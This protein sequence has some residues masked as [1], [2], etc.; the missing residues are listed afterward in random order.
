MPLKISNGRLMFGYLELMKVES[1][2]EV[3]EPMGYGAEPML[4]QGK[5]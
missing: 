1:L 4:E 3:L 5:N 2:T